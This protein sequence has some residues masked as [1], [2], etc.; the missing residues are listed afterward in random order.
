[1]SP[2]GACFMPS[3]TSRSGC[4]SRTVTER[5]D[6]PVVGIYWWAGGSRPLKAGRLTT[7]LCNFDRRSRFAPD[8]L[9]A[10][11][12]MLMCPH[13]LICSPPR[14]GS[15][16]LKREEILPLGRKRM[17]DPSLASFT[18]GHCNFR[19]SGF[20]V[21]LDATFWDCQ[22]FADVNPP[23]Y[24]LAALWLILRRPRAGASG[25]RF[26]VARRSLCM[27]ELL[28]CRPLNSACPRV[29]R[30]A[31]RRCRTS[32]PSARAPRDEIVI[33]VAADQLQRAV[34]LDHI[35]FPG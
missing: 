32:N 26:C 29:L 28:S 14:C 10:R 35:G 18:A 12:F 34:L 11:A 9:C 33:N 6:I 7:G 1:M 17:S 16:S 5:S 21:Q 22:G 31:Q 25:E 4:R 8:D 27:L 2:W 30:D 3:G 13:A 19:I 15:R 23:E 20:Q 24:L